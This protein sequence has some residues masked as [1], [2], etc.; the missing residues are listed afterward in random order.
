[1]FHT[2]LLDHICDLLVRGGATLAHVREIR[3]DLDPLDIWCTFPHDMILV[4]GHVVGSLM[5]IRS[6]RA[7]A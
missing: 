4:M 1:M 7:H 2:E 5:L 6:L 3:F